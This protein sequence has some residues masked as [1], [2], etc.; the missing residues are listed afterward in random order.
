MTDNLERL[1]IRRQQW[2]RAQGPAWLLRHRPGI[3]AQLDAEIARLELAAKETKQVGRS[4]ARQ[5]PNH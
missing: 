4:N 5:H 2:Q 1:K 3:I